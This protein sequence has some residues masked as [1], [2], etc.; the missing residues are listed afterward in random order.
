MDKNEFLIIA[1]YADESKLS[2]SEV[3]EICSISKERLMELVAYEILSQQQ[4]REMYFD[5]LQLHRL[6]KALRLQRDLD[7]NLAG[8]AI[9][10]D[11]QDQLRSRK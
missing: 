9:I 6:Q 4:A 2:L 3:C 7:L 1:D 10:L 11:L 8:I 5:L